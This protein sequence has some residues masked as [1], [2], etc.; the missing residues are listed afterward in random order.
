[1]MKM[2]LS[3]FIWFM[4]LASAVSANPYASDKNFVYVYYNSYLDLRT[5]SVQK[6]SPP[7]FIVKGDIVHVDT[8]SNT[9]SLYADIT[10]K[11]DLL[12]HST[13][14]CNNKTGNWKL[15]NTFGTS[16]EETSNRKIADALFKAAFGW[17]FYGENFS[18]SR[19][20]INESVPALSMN[21]LAIGGIQIGASFERVRSIYGS[22]NKVRRLAGRDL[23]FWSGNSGEVWS[24]GNSFEITFIDGTARVITSKASNGIK[25]ADGISVGDDAGKLWCTYGLAYSST[26]NAYLY[27]NLSVFMKF[28]MSDE[29]I[30]EISIFVEG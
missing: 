24:Y 11:F 3:V 10:I 28:T 21:R 16:S 27:R 5:V 20:G 26:E 23:R 2:F 4:L 29:K 25:T 22:P 19:L 30:S 6:N 14:H 13:F 1:M 17:E 8:K 15:G 7:Y 9:A 12:A 18:R